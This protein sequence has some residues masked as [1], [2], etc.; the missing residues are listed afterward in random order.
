MLFWLITVFLDVC[1]CL[2][3]TIKH[4]IECMLYVF[5]QSTYYSDEKDQT[6]EPMPF[7][8]CAFQFF[9]NV[10]CDIDQYSNIKW[11]GGWLNTGDKSVDL[12][13]W[14]AGETSAAP[15]WDRN[16]NREQESYY[17]EPPHWQIML[18]AAD[19]TVC[20]SHLLQCNLVLL[21]GCNV[22]LLHCQEH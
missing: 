13:V 7:S 1:W 12:P 2:H 22:K 6:P 21:S 11:K 18:I 9:S 4:C 15:H 8:C 16:K 19:T 5:G 17:L 20:Q 10:W 14:G 3:Q